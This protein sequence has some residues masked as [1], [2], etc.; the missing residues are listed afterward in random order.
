M[1]L[2]EYGVLGITGW[3]AFD[4]LFAVA[5]ARF[6]SARLRA[7]NQLEGTHLVRP[8]D[9]AVRSENAYFEELTGGPFELSFKKTS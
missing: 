7:E 3:V 8:I 1:R 4:V 5:W 2:I 9:G 6:H